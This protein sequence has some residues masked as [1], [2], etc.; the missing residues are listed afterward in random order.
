[1]DGASKTVSV[2]EM[3]CVL[4][5][6]VVHSLNHLRLLGTG[7]DWV[8]FTNPWLDLAAVITLLYLMHISAGKKQGKF[9]L[10]HTI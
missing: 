5:L 2:V 4:L 3:L 8:G 9:E 6:Q 1:M 10:F 7:E